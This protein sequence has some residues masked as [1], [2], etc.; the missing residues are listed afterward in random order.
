MELLHVELVEVRWVLCG[1]SMKMKR[2]ETTVPGDRR[3]PLARRADP[4]VGPAHDNFATVLLG[5]PY[6]EMIALQVQLVHCLIRV[7]IACTEATVLLL[8]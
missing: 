5:I 4:S 6:L 3:H 1:K 8:P 2:R 7:H